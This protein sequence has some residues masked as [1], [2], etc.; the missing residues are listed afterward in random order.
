MVL[1]YRSDEDVLQA[2]LGSLLDARSAEVASTAAA[3]RSVYA[4]RVARAVAG[5]V[6]SLGG[7]ATLLGGAAHCLTTRSWLFQSSPNNSLLF[8]GFLTELLVGSVAASALVYLPARGVAASLFSRAL[9]DELSLAGSV[10]I[11]LVR[12]ERAQPRRIARRLIEASE[13][14]SASL[15]LIGSALLAPLALHFLVW[16]LLSR[17][18]LVGGFEAFDGWIAASAPIAGVAHLVLA[19]LAGRFGSKLAEVPTAELVAR[20]AKEGWRALK[21][22]TLAGMVPGVLVLIPPLLIGLTGLLFIPLSFHA[23][24]RAVVRERDAVDAQGE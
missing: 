10:R 24:S 20:P 21:I 9:R 6:A 7:A 22:T 4:R 11:D 8:G 3:L 14:L 12:V 2:R 16:L 15:P 19:T 23:M 18:D 13:S 5:G 17:G 1:A